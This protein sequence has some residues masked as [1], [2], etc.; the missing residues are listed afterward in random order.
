[1]P[2]CQ[3]TL[4]TGILS[5]NR[6]ISVS[7]AK[8]IITNFVISVL[9]GACTVGTFVVLRGDGYWSYYDGTLNISSYLM[10]VNLYHYEGRDKS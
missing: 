10:F 9:N 1:M 6:I 5:M 7:G 8:K 2:I 4:C 3:H